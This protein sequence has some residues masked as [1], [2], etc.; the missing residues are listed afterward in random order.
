[1]LQASPP[2]N[3]SHEWRG[4]GH[5]RLRLTHYPPGVRQGRH[6]HDFT[7]ISFLLAGNME[8]RIGG[9]CHPVLRPAVAIKPAGTDHADAWGRHGS[10]ILSIETDGDRTVPGRVVPWV[11][12][13]PRPVV[14]AI[15]GLLASSGDPVDEVIDDLIGCLPASR[16]AGPPPP[17]LARVCEALA[18]GEA[19]TAAGAARIAGVHR[20]H[21]SRGF[22]RHLGVGFGAYRRHAMTARAVQVTLR[23][24]APLA[25]VAQVAGFADQSHMQR[26]FRAA[27][28]VT[29][30]RLRAMLAA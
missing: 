11:G 26:T 28:A 25:E 30:R 16:P 27:L 17:W 29:P 9:T 4:A 3:L 18:D 10:L 15:A 23:T 5:G 7:Q 2:A 12:L 14:T 19:L 8:E 21:L 24:A 1:M 13:D 20:V 22:V 6:A